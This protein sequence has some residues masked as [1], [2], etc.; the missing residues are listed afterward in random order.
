[1]SQPRLMMMVSLRWFALVQ[2]SAFSRQVVLPGLADPDAHV[3]GNT[4]YIVGTFD[5]KVLPIWR[6]TTSSAH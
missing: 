6:M 1:M 4:A 5:S 3:E 2:L